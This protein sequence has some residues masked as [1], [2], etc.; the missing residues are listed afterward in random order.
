MTKCKDMSQFTKV[1]INW[2]RPNA[3]PLINEKENYSTSQNAFHVSLDSHCSVRNMRGQDILRLGERN[4]RFNSNDSGI[5]R[6]ALMDPIP[7][8]GDTQLA[9]VPDSTQALPLGVV[10]GGHSHSGLSH[11]FSKLHADL[12]SIIVLCP[13]LFITCKL[14]LVESSKT[15]LSVPRVF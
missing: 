9:V 6:W 10:R 3:V 4:E 8:R 13:G 11:Q 7:L 12:L 5:D 2:C 15:D 14:F 1:I